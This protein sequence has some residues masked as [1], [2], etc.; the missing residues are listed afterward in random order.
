M[1]G[2]Q[3]AY[4]WDQFS[5]TPF[6]QVLGIDLR[7]A[8]QVSYPLSHLACPHPLDFAISSCV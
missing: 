7:V 5:L 4:L 8:Q 6:A 1:C 3:R 2:G